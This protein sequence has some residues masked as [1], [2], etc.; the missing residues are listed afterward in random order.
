MRLRLRRAIRC[1]LAGLGAISL[2]VGAQVDASKNPSSAGV[3][4]GSSQAAGWLVPDLGFLIAIVLVA[5]I[6]V[7][8]NRN[9]P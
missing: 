8:R 6:V 7:A 1:T 5:L 3:T 9:A 4:D 2:H